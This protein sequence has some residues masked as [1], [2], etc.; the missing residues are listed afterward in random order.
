VVL[1]HAKQE[2][3]ETFSTGRSGLRKSW[4]CAE[5][6]DQKCNRPFRASTEL[7]NQHGGFSH[8]YLACKC[9]TLFSTGNTITRVPTLTRL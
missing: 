8:M 3:K 5:R 9:G 1:K 6:A 7:S 4:Y 2:I